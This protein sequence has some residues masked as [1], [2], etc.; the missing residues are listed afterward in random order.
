MRVYHC[1]HSSSLS[2]PCQSEGAFLLSTDKNQDNSEEADTR[3]K[4]IQN[5][6]EV[7]SDPREK[8][9]CDPAYRSRSHPNW[10]VV[11]SVQAFGI[12][13]HVLCGNRYD[14]HRDQILQAGRHQAGADSGHGTQQAP[15]EDLS[16]FQYFSSSC[17]NGYHDEA[18]V[19]PVHLLHPTTS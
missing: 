4:E 1:A 19:R 14:N 17:Y 8:A 10:T 2:Q 5:A 11:L 16:L 7:L 9:W 6:W 15:P 13:T 12:Y 18:A 3:F